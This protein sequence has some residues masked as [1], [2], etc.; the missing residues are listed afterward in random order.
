MIR[1]SAAMI[2]VAIV[3]LVTGVIASSLVLVYA[4]IGVSALAAVAL[5]IGVLRHKDEIFGSAS[6][7]RPEQ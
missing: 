7:G 3:V 6:A 4:S 2:A 5:G 1:S